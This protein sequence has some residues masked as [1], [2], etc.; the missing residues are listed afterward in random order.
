MLSLVH[1]DQYYQIFMSQ[2]LGMGIGAGMI[3]TPAMAI[4]AH[5]WKV[6]RSLVMGLVITGTP[7]ICAFWLDTHI[8]TGSSVGGIVYPI[9]L[10]NLFNSSV[11]FAQGVR[12]SGYL[13][14]GLLVLANGL[15]SAKPRGGIKERPTANVGEILR[16]TPYMLVGVVG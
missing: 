8:R 7:M 11:G 1:I 14:A 4:Q 2:G 13:T 9:M 16:D 6:H 10:N 15:M 5:H 12:A 3:Y